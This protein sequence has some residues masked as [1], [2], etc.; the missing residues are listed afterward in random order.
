LVWHGVDLTYG[1]AMA[2]PVPDKL[3]P[4]H[5]AAVRR[6]L[7]HDALGQPSEQNGS[8]EQIREQ[9]ERSAGFSRPAVNDRTLPSQRASVRR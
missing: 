8:A 7:A 9:Q 4:G 3:N 2:K 1:V 6:M 5:D